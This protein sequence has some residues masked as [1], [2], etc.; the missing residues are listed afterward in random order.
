MI[1]RRTFRNE[2]GREIKLRVYETTASDVV[3]EMV[4]PTSMVENIFTAHE[5][6]MLLHALQQVS[7]RDPTPEFSGTDENAFIDTLE[8][9][10]SD[11][12]RL[13]EGK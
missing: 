1:V 8:P 3:V 6:R 4:G 5:A 11:E 2:M 9:S 13:T 7:G 12:T 10:K